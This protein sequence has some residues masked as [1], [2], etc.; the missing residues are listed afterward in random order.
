MSYVSSIHHWITL[1]E[2]PVGAYGM[3]Q[4]LL[5]SI[6]QNTVMMCWGRL[7]MLAMYCW[8]F[9]HSESY[10]LR[11]LLHIHRHQYIRMGIYPA[12]LTLTNFIHI[13]TCIPINVLGYILFITGTLVLIEEISYKIFY[14]ILC[15]IHGPFLQIRCLLIIYSVLLYV[16]H[17]TI[18][19]HSFTPASRKK[20]GGLLEEGERAIERR[21]SRPATAG[22][23]KT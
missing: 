14:H 10:S 4:P 19:N 5:G 8:P 2:V 9:V 13:F 21:V 17:H 16:H 7:F 12:W 6:T 20:W 22:E 15:A 11:L 3:L 18:G 1:S 23:H